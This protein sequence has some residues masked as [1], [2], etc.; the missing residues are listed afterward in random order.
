M[1]EEQLILL[2]K[3]VGAIV[4]IVG[5]L[6]GLYKYVIYP[7]Y[8]RILFNFKLFWG[9]ILDVA[10][11][12]E[13]IKKEFT[14]NGG[15]SI[16]DAIKR[17]ECKVNILE[18]KNRAI[19]S[20]D[21]RPIFKTNETGNYIWINDAFV[22]EIGFSLDFLKNGGWISMIEESD[23]KRVKEAWN[24]SILDKRSFL[25]KFTILKSNDAKIDVICSA[26]PIISEDNNL[27]GYIGTMTL[28]K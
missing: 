23:R 26:C 20:L 17:I 27:I 6:V 8:K 3:A 7:I 28:D 4:T 10:S 19:L 13:I 9:V 21:T 14:T 25:S 11:I 22:K 16:K 15:S 12:H 1:T 5:A 24:E 18:F 2:G